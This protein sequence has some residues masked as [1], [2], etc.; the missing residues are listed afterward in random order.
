MKANLPKQLDKINVKVITKL[1]TSLVR[2]GAVHAFLFSI[3][4]I[5]IA[6]VF[7][8]ITYFRYRDLGTDSEISLTEGKSVRFRNDLYSEIMQNLNKRQ[9]QF[10]K[11]I[12]EYHADPFYLWELPL[13]EE[14]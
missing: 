1:L 2:M 13:T 12:G 9:E 10:R 11:A 3:A 4:F 6:F 5:I 7:G 14:K 8:A